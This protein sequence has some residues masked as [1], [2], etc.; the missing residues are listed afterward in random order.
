[1]FLVFLL[2][3]NGA[4]GAEDS[5]T[6]P[7]RISSAKLNKCTRKPIIQAGQGFVLAFGRFACDVG[8]AWAGLRGEFPN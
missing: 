6:T 8:M 7:F 3:I 2:L 4:P 1:M 5:F